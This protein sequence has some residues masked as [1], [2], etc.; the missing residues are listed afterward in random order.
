MSNKVKGV[1]S[2][3]GSKQ[4]IGK[5][6]KLEFVIK[7]KEGKNGEYERML[8]IGLWNKSIGLLDGIGLGQEIEAEVNLGSREWQGKYFTEVTAYKITPVGGSSSNAA[9]AVVVDD[10]TDSLPF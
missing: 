8:A 5:N 7:W 3:I 6:D 2:H 10:D 1:I 9:P 4:T